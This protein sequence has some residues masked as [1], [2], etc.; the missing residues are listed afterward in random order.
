[1]AGGLEIQ[2]WEHTFLKNEKEKNSFLS[3][4]LE[5]KESSEERNLE[6]S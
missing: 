1:M 6:I 5:P 2:T 4:F 3:L